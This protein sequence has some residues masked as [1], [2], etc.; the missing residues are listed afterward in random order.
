MFVEEALFYGLGGKANGPADFSTSPSR[1]QH[2]AWESFGSSVC[3]AMGVHI[4]DALPH[5]AFSESARAPANSMMLGA[6]S[7]K[8]LGR[9]KEPKKDGA[10]LKSIV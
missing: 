9:S 1:G 7:R 2:W 3:Q 5:V 6:V 4:V 10:R 8:L